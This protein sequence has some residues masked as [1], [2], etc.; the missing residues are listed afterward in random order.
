M[1]F[2]KIFKNIEKTEWL[3]FSHCLH[4]EN[5]EFQSSIWAIEYYIQLAF[6]ELFKEKWWRLV[7]DLIFLVFTQKQELRVSFKLLPFHNMAMIILD[8]QLKSAQK[9]FCKCFLC[10]IPNLE[11]HKFFSL[12]KNFL[13]LEVSPRM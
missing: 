7:K 13:I 2:L 10:M 8:F 1:F 3:F 4:V 5:L 6:F 12:I 9:H 11:C